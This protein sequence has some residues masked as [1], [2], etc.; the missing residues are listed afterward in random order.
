MRPHLVT[1][2]I[3][4]H[5]LGD[6]LE[7]ALTD[8]FEREWGISADLIE[9]STADVDRI[10]LCRSLNSRRKIHTVSNQILTLYYHVRKVK[11]EPHPERLHLGLAQ[12]GERAPYLDCATHRVDGTRK[13]G[14][15]R[16]ASGLEDAAVEQTHFI[17]D[18]RMAARK[19]F[20]GSLLGLL[21]Q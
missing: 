17:H 2:P 1:D 5:A 15:C 6:I 16:I 7:G 19:A 14:E 21:H 18:K 8:I 3:E 9:E 12:T 13:F 4:V 10:R 20:S 11:S